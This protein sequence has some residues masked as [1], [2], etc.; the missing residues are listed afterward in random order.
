[1][2]ET[3]ADPVFMYEWN[4]S[5][6]QCTFDSLSTAVTV[7]FQCKHTVFASR[8]LRISMPLHRYECVV[9]QNCLFLM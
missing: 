4:E 8:K 3:Q 5:N 2:T 9:L 7:N 6:E 1:M